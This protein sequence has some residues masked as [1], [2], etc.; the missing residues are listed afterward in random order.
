MT[1]VLC[2]LGSPTSLTQRSR[3]SANRCL[4]DTLPSLAETAV[5]VDALVADDYDVASPR[6]SPTAATQGAGDS[7]DGPHSHPEPS[8]FLATTRSS[9]DAPRITPALPTLPPPPGL[10]RTL[11][12]PDQIRAT[13][14]EHATGMAPIASNTHAHPEPP[15]GLLQD[16]DFPALGAV[17][18]KG[19]SATPRSQTPKPA[20]KK[21]SEKAPTKV[22]DVPELASSKDDKSRGPV[23]KQAI[24]IDTARMSPVADS[25]ASTTDTPVS[26]SQEMFPPL[27]ASTP[28]ARAAPKTLRLVANTKLETPPPESPSLTATSSAS[29]SAIASRAVSALQRPDTPVSEMVS[30][31][32]SVVSA[33]VSASRAG[34]PPPSKVGSAAVRT[35]TKSQVRKQRKEATKQESKVIAEAPKAEPEIHAPILGRMKKQKKEKPAKATAKIDPKSQEVKAADDHER[36]TVQSSQSRASI[37]EPIVPPPNAAKPAKGKERA[38]TKDKVQ[39]QPIFIPEPIES[40]TPVEIPQGPSSVFADIKESLW[41]SQESKLLFLKQI[42]NGSARASQ[43]VARVSAGTSPCGESPCRCGEIQDEDLTTLRSGKPVRKQFHTDGSRMLITPNGDC[44]RGLTAEEEDLFLQ[45]QVSIA[46]S[47]DHPGAF[48]APR[49]Q[50]SNGGAFSLIKGRAVPNGRPSIFPVAPLPQSQDP[51]VKIQREDALS[52]I[53]QYVLPRLSLGAANPGAPKGTSPTRDA[54]AASLNSLAPYFYGPDAAAGVGIY[55]PTDGA[56]ALQDFGSHHAHGQ[57][58]AKVPGVSGVP[59]MPLMS[60]EDAE[61]A[62]ALARKETDKMEK[63]LNALL[64]RNRRILLSGSA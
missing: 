29:A 31:T 16:E 43:D 60:V 58:G 45:L 14:P 33:S 19:H 59:S 30:D 54:A 13:R 21:P 17:K 49:H 35:A 23:A 55:S 32:A 22:L 37:V 12:K 26:G 27:P 24:A 56:R 8:M 48:V 63:S 11:V 47:A 36:E 5:S 44:V 2:R 6:G 46:E 20:A 62:L 39:E 61:T 3:H 25:L 15:T 50:P 9:L 18:A 52:Y 64:K 1:P 51:L 40:D 41:S 53:N 57:D 38:A 7:W 42:A 4:D 10:G 34:S 28:S